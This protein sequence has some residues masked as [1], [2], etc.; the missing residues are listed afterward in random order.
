LLCKWPVY[1]FSIAETTCGAVDLAFSGVPNYDLTTN[2]E[3]SAIQEAMMHRHL[4]AHN[5][6]LVD[7]DYIDKLRRITGHDLASDSRIS[8]SYP[9]DDTYWFEPLKSLNTLI[10]S[11]RRFFRAF[12]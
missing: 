5:S 8:A 6:G 11:T 7:D 1:R 12:P 4:Y 9:N 2:P 3:L 10:E